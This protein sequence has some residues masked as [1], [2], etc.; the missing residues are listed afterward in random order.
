[1]QAIFVDHVQSI[2]EITTL[3]KTDRELFK[4]H[5]VINDLE[6]I[7]QHDS[8]ET[9]KFLF[10][11]PDGN[12][13]ETVLMY[14][15][16][17]KENAEVNDRKILRSWT[18]PNFK[19][20]T[21]KLNRITICISSQVG[22][23]VG[24]IFCVTGKLGFKKNLSRQQIIG[25]I[26]FA[27][28]F[29]KQKFGKK[30]DGTWN[31]VRNV[32]FMG[33]G[34]PLL[35]YDSMKRSIECMLDQ[36]SL[37]LS[38]RHVTIS[39]S[40]VVRYIDQLVADGID[41]R[42]AL[43]LHSPNQELREKL[44]PMIAKKR[45]IEDLMRS[46]DNYVQATDNRVFYEYIMIKDTTDTPEIAHQLGKLLQD[47]HAHVNLIPYNENPAMPDLATSEY[48]MIMKFKRIVEEYD[49]TVTV[50]DTLGR[51]VKGACGQLGYEKIMKA[52]IEEMD[53]MENK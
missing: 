1:M 21:H 19:E 46:I 39:T 9:T 16:H 11:L 44:I 18:N 3:S 17:E 10:K 27:N 38:K 24:C 34:E 8:D 6:C 52:R 36:Q 28:S 14:H 41:V 2:D 37:G 4:E 26:L 42:L 20:E 15:R 33:M 13:I 32:V 51:N 23:A 22:C 25:Q 49:V 12:V 45:P 43:S 47:R 53:R 29:I 30:E 48:E 31:K 5:F 40:G 50:R 7:E 35:N